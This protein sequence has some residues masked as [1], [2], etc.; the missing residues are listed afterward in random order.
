MESYKKVFIF[1]P[2]SS[3]CYVA[4]KVG[5]NNF[6]IFEYIVI[7]L[8]IQEYFLQITF[9]LGVKNNILIHIHIISYFANYIHIFSRSSEKIIHYTLGE[10]A[11]RGSGAGGVG[12]RS[13]VTCNTKHIF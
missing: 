9:L 13:Q 3:D 1:S 10:L 12:D 4:V 11:G 5:F 7:I 8:Y 6:Q 2:Q